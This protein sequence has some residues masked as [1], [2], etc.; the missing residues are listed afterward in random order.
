MKKQTVRVFLIL[1]LSILISG[2]SGKIFENLKNVK[3][4][5]A[6]QEQFIGLTREQVVERFGKPATFQN[7]GAVRSDGQADRI[8][9]LTYP[10]WNWRIV[11]ILKNDIVTEV[12]YEMHPS[13]KR[14]LQQ[15]KLQQQK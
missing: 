12:K 1:T 5:I 13:L 9:I 11:A 15:Q 6:K 7:I 8:E 10:T 2:C 14:K 4:A 3:Q